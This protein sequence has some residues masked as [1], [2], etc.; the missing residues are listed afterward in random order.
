MTWNPNSVATGPVALEARSSRWGRLLGFTAMTLFWNGI[1]GVFVHQAWQ[2]FARGRPDGFLMLFLVP[3][4]LIGLG[5]VAALVHSLLALG[6]A[7]PDL[8]ASTRTPRLGERLDLQWRLRGRTD[9]LTRVRITLKGR[10]Q[11]TYQVGTDTRTASEDFFERV[12]VDAPAPTCAMGG[13]ATVSVPDTAMHSFE[14]GHNQVIWELALVGEIRRWPDV[15]E[16]YPLVVLPL[17]AGG[18]KRE[19]RRP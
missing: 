13:H 2:G 4:V 8:V 9:S 19:D 15:K 6:N 11:A 10:E 5:F 3:F 12:L 16:T 14:S 17:A 1:V 18:A 7:R